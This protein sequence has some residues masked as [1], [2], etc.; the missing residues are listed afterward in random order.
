LRRTASIAVILSLLMSSAA[1]AA[2]SVVV[3]DANDVKGLL[4]IRRLTVGWTDSRV[5]MAISTYGPWKRRALRAKSNFVRASFT[6]PEDSVKIYDLQIFAVKRNGVNRL[7]AAIVVDGQ[8]VGTA[9]VRKTAPNTVRV[10]LARSTIED[11]GTTLLFAAG[12]YYKNKKKS[13]KK[14]CVDLSPD[15]GSFWQVPID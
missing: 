7:V 8:H 1:Q 5:S 13:C 14:R 10:S 6:G 12:S 9:R 4:D 2:G 11:L 15:D 3:R